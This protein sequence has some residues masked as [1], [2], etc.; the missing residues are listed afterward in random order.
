MIRYVLFIAVCVIAALYFAHYRVATAT[1]CMAMRMLVPALRVFIWGP[2]IML[3]D[4][5]ALRCI[6]L[7]LAL[8]KVT[9]S[10]GVGVMICTHVRQ[11]AG[12]EGRDCAVR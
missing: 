2:Y 4:R 6:R 1:V 9:L 12:D 7:G 10:H 3:S 11:R 5:A 8:G